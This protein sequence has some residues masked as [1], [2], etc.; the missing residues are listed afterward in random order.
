MIA[1]F[2]WL[3][4]FVSLPDDIRSI[5]TV[6]SDLGFEVENISNDKV[7]I[8]VTPNRSDMLSISGIAKELAIKFNNKIQTKNEKRVKFQPYSKLVNIDFE[9]KQDIINFGGLVI[10]NANITSSPD[11]IKTRLISCGINPINNFVDLTNY[12]MIETGQPLHAFDLDSIDHHLTL[13]KSKKNESIE[14]LN[15]NTI[16][17]GENLLVY[18]SNNRI[19]DLIGIMGGKTSG[20]VDTTKN[21]FVQA[22]IFQP[23]IIR[24]ASKSCKTSTP[25]S[26]RY[27]RGIDE[28]QTTKTILKFKK[29]IEQNNWGKVEEIF[30]NEYNPTEQKEI[31]LDYASINKLI[32]TNFQKDFCIKALELIGCKI[33]GNKILTP[34][35]RKDILIWQD[36]A[37]EIARIYGYN[38][39]M[40]KLIDKSDNE[41][42]NTNYWNKYALKKQLV[43]LG[44][45]EVSTYSFLSDDETKIIQSNTNDLVR[46]INPLSN[47]HKS[48]RNSLIP[49]LLKTAS[50]NPWYS[51]IKIFEIG[52]IFTKKNEIEHLALLSHKKLNIKGE[53]KINPQDK[54]YSIFKIKKPYYV[55]ECSLF[56]A[57]KI[58]D[59]NKNV[60]PEEFT[61]RPIKYKSFS[62]LYPT[63][64]DI[65]IIVD[66]SVQ[67]QAI[68][69]SLEY[70]VGHIFEIDLFDKF[71]N[72]IL[73]ENKIS[74]AFHL[75]FDTQ[76]INLINECYQK[77]LI[78]L[79]NKFN[80]IIR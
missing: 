63:V 17:L 80:A 24:I 56:D 27:E 29:I 1:P 49:L 39:L 43:S 8:E 28:Q 52:N 23:N 40:V 73:G 6:F 4:E 37:E 11:Y 57:K 25:A 14:L 68:E 48:L 18:E 61:L 66:K 74:Y 20:I 2:D 71:E 5:E 41:I 70:E 54:L 45:S 75:I 22:A 58:I 50:K 42:Q 34:T 44:F 47:E 3:S 9:E 46:I 15:G 67:Y 78:I 32:G 19:V 53:I 26:Y 77:S 76:D 55:Y 31:L 13:R 33:Q 7:E 72:N 21:I 60:N 59:F 64:M 79:T 36:L 16:N 10:N 51:N 12:L 38:N 69:K 62:K 35:H 30:F 65:S